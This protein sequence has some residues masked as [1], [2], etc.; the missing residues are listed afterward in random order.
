M[1]CANLA[2]LL[3]ARGAARHQQTALD[4]P[5]APH[6]GGSYAPVLTEKLAPFLDRRCGWPLLAYAGRKAILLLASV[7]LR[8]SYRRPRLA[9]ILVFALLLSVITGVILAVAPRMD[10][11]PAG[12]SEGCM[13]AVEVPAHHPRPPEGA[14]DHTG[15]LSS[16]LLSVAGLSRRVCATWRTGDSVS[17]P[18]AGSSQPSISL[19]RDINP[20]S[21]RPSINNSRIGSI[22][23]P[24]C[25]APVFHSTV[26]KLAAAGTAISASGPF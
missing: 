18:A 9:S 14:R 3:L 13:A 12:P 2:N 22:R 15:H 24:V 17:R 4:V 8:L 20:S 19:A 11:Q 1:A 10:R 6:A 26:R 23:S 21:F 5:P 16:V 7:A 25:A